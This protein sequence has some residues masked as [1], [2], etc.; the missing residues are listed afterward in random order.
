MKVVIWIHF[1]DHSRSESHLL[2][3]FA[4]TVLTAIAAFG[5]Q[6]QRDKRTRQLSPPVEQVDAAGSFGKPPALQ[7]NTYGN[8][9][10][11]S[12]VFSG[13]TETCSAQRYDKKLKVSSCFET[14]PKHTPFLLD[15]LVKDANGGKNIAQ[16]NIPVA[17]C[18]PP[19]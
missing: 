7:R 9:M 15:L 14:P 13:S 6:T 12:Q 10:K 4:Q 1:G 2:S 11:M 16:Q 17:L 3:T 18:S 8:C 19:D 5:P